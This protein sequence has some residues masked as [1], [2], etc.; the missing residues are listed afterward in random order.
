[1]IPAFSDDPARRL[2]GIGFC[3]LGY[4]LFSIQDVLV[5]LL[6]T[7]YAVPQV[8]FFRSVIIV[9]IALA[10][11][12]RAGAHAIVHSRNKLALSLR[13]A[14]MLVAWLSFYSA[15]RHLG[16]AQ[17]TTIYFAAPIIVVALSV[18]ILKEKVTPVRWACVLAGFGGVV[19]AADPRGGLETN[20]ALW[21]LFAAACW[22]LSAILVRLI[23]RSESTTNQMVVSNV[24]FTLACLVM[25]PFV[26]VMPDGRGLAMLAGLGLVGGLGQYFLY[27]GFRTAPASAVAPIEYT[28]LVWA[29]LY[30][31]VI[32]ADVPTPQV[33]A[34]ALIIV[35]SSL[36]LI[37]RESLSVREQR[38]LAEP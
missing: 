31:Y 2:G 8:L 1:M 26:W 17:L 12:G 16:L 29:F 11:G 34:G 22:A 5:K 21:A 15:A 36:V 3:A 9:A 37:W 4:S 35:A 6:V 19:L 25:L 23:S 24:L 18:V 14:L 30:G 20:P 38:A 7:T 33:V 32:W 13:A 10:I 28:G 27:E